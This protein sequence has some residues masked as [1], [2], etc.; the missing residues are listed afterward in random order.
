MKIIWKITPQDIIDTNQKVIALKLDPLDEFCVRHDVLGDVFDMFDKLKVSDD[1]QGLLKKGA[2]LMAYITWAQPFC[3]GN[4]R[5]AILI[6]ANFFHH[7]GVEMVIPDDGKELR[8]LLYEIQEDRSG[9]NEAVMERIIFY[10]SK[11]LV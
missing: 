7:N 8:K 3:A 11:T 9:L 10:I 2:H 6:T 1:L 4:K 5:T